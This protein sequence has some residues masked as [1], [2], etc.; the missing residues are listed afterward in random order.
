MRDAQHICRKLVQILSDIHDR[1]IIHRELRPEKILVKDLEDS[2]D[3]KFEITL[4]SFGFA[5]KEE[6]LFE[7]DLFPRVGTLEY[8]PIEMLLPGCCQS[9]PGH[10]KIWYD[11]RVDIWSLGVIIFEML[12]GQTPF[13]T[14]SQVKTLPDG[15]KVDCKDDMTMEKICNLKFKFPKL[16]SGAVYSEAEDLFRC[17]FVKPDDRITLAE[18]KQHPWLLKKL[19]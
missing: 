15:K 1:G 4:T 3:S 17:I 10:F 14:P 13:Y 19:K 6:E 8:C 9:K 2:Y 18:M 11:R 16:F 12:Y 5:I 7:E